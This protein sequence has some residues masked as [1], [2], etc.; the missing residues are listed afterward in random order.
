L[1]ENHK[2]NIKDWAEEDRPREKL[3]LKGKDSLTNAELIAILI[4]SGNR[5]ETA[6]A[7]SQRI[8]QSVENNLNELGKLSVVNLMTKFKGIGEAKAITILSALELGR[9]RKLSDIL[10]RKDITSSRAGFEYMNT[11]LEDLTH[12]EFWLV[13]L[14]TANKILSRHKISQGGLNQTLV[15]KRI[16]VRK[17][18]EENATAVILFH[19]HPTGNR[20]ASESDKKITVEIKKALDIFDIRLLD[21]IIIAGKTYFSF[22]D[23][24][25]LSF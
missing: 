3:L 25:L 11:V 8:L 17:A 18:L 16:I 10:E 19:N 7:L 5:E 21:H 14:N 24:G 20:S 15:D 22:A 4:G 1:E 13:L 9:R 2:I 23:E 12:E 6:V